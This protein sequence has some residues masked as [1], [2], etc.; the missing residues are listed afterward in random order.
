[1]PTTASHLP[2][3]GS[4]NTRCSP[5]LARG[6]LAAAASRLSGA[7]PPGR[8]SCCGRSGAAGES[9]AAGESGA[10]ARP[11]PE[12]ASSSAA[13]PAPPRNPRRARSAHR[14]PPP[15]TSAFLT[16]RADPRPEAAAGETRLDLLPGRDRG[17]VGEQ[18]TARGARHD[19]EAARERRERADG[20]QGTLRQSEAV[21]RARQAFA[22]GVLQA[23]PGPLVPHAIFP[24]QLV[25]RAAHQCRD[26]VR[27][28]HL[29]AV[30]AG[31]RR[32]AEALRELIETLHL[33]L[34][35]H[36]RMRQ[37]QAPPDVL[38][39]RA[40]HARSEEHTSELQSRSDL[41]CRLLLEKKKK[42]Q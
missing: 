14:V 15:D 3:T 39:A 36:P 6:A 5:K 13:Q 24:H 37:L 42:Q 30:Q 31:V 28:T 26:A 7:T 19:G 20:I 4:T 33:L 21:L 35:P 11:T 34:Q 40:V 32:R 12:H 8:S 2:C 10:P 23:C 27:E 38:Q 1:M 16:A 22:G 9:A 29:I 17:G 18:R 41:V 25:R